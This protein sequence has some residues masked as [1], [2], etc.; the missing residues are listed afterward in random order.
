MEVRFGVPK[1]SQ[2][3]SLRLTCSHLHFKASGFEIPSSAKMESRFQNNI[4]SDK[5]SY[6][7]SKIVISYED[8]RYKKHC[9][10]WYFLVQSYC[11]MNITSMM[12]KKSK[13]WS[14]KARND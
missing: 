4:L 13:V 5:D 7:K 14:I 2:I 3:L 12:W 9:S 6:K 11:K 8:D 10:T 1:K